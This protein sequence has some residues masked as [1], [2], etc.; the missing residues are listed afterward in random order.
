MSSHAPAEHNAEVTTTAFLVDGGFVTD[1]MRDLDLDGRWRD[2]QS[3][4]MD[5]LPGLTAEDAC[6]VLSGEK[7]FVGVNEVDLV[8]ADEDERAAVRS[9]QNEVLSSLVRVDD[10]SAGDGVLCGDFQVQG[11][12]VID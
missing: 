5:S 6:S 11:V 3:C 12:R 1:R 9:R 2:A 7:T 4:L 10:R 8:D